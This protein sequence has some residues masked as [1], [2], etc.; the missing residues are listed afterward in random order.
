MPPKLS[1]QTLGDDAIICHACN[2]EV[3]TPFPCP[4]CKTP[5]HSR[6]AKK[7]TVLENRSFFVEFLQFIIPSL[8]SD[9]SNDINIS[10]I[11]KFSSA[12][13]HPRPLKIYCK[14]IEKAQLIFDSFNKAKQTL[15]TREDF[16]S[17]IIAPD[18][19]K[20]QQTLY[21]ELKVILEERRSKGENVSIKYRSGVPTIVQNSPKIVITPK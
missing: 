9:F 17:I 1:P 4:V 13:L 11:G 8:S 20:H 5:Y 12:R 10:R 7:C 6:C 19:T 18:R 3:T 2:S 14:S 16:K 21:R 15:Q